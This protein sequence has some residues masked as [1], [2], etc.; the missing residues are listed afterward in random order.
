MPE[1][2]NDADEKLDSILSHLKDSAEKLDAMKKDAAEDRKRLD[3]VCSRMD[4]FEK[5]KAD[6]EEEDKKKADAARK[7]AEEQEA[8]VKADAEA[9]ESKKKADAEA[10]EAKKKADAARADAGS[11]A[12]LR[13]KIDALTK[14]IPAQLS[15]DQRQRM[16]GFQSKAERVFQAF[17]DSAGAPPPVNGETEVDYRVRL[18]SAFKKHSKAYKDSDLGKVHDEA[19]FTSIEDSIYADAYT[20]ATRPTQ[21]QPGVLIPQ[22]TKD[23][24]GRV[25]TRYNGDPNAAWAPFMQPPRY[26]KNFVVPGRTN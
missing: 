15:S 11:H 1:V 17:G 16:T 19:I 6:A 9:E 2:K 21:V 22:R 7:D 10:E 13:A 25:I 18:L 8:K 4:G 3:A 20:E 14:L 24:T 23:A 12:D 26:V 5:A